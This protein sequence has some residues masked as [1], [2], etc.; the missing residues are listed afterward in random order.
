MRLRHVVLPAPLG[1][2]RLTISPV[3]TLKLISDSASNPPNRV[4][5][6]SISSI[7]SGSAAVRLVS[8]GDESHDA[9]RQEQH[10]GHHDQAENR[11]AQ[12]LEIAEVLFQQYDNDGADDRTDQ[13]PLASGKHHDDHGDHEGKAEHLRPDKGD[14][15]GVKATGQT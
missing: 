3:P 15:I 2:I 7:A 10:H 14:I 5:T 12:L 8:P 9:A 13:R 11:K 4:E 1:P 6:L